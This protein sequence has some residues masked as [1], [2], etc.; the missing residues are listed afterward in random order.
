M[1]DDDTNLMVSLVRPAKTWKKE[2]SEKKK[3]D[4]H[5]YSIVEIGQN[6]ELNLRGL[7]RIVVTRTPMK[8]QQLTPV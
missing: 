8:D 2:K 1:G 6:T 3:K 4:N 7:W 5:S